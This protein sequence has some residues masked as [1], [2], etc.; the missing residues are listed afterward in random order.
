MVS[1]QSLSINDLP[2]QFQEVAWD[3][4]ETYRSEHFLAPDAS[5]TPV[6]TRTILNYNGDTQID[7]ADYDA[8]RR[9]GSF[10]DSGD[11]YVF[12]DEFLEFAQYLKKRGGGFGALPVIQTDSVR[13]FPTAEELMISHYR[14]LI[15]DLPEKYRGLA[16]KLIDIWNRDN[17][18][19]AEALTPI[20]AK[21]VFNPLPCGL[22]NVIDAN[23]YE[24][25][26]M[27]ILGSP[28][29]VTPN[30][31]LFWGLAE[32]LRDS[33][34]YQNLPPIYRD[35]MPIPQS[36]FQQTPTTQ[37]KLN[38]IDDL[39]SKWIDVEDIPATD[40]AREE[41]KQCYLM[42]YDAMTLAVKEKPALFDAEML[43]DMNRHDDIGFLHI[44]PPDD[45][46]SPANDEENFSTVVRDLS[47]VRQF[48]DEVMVASG[49]SGCSQTNLYYWLEAMENWNR[50]LANYAQSYDGHP[51]AFPEVPQSNSEITEINWDDFDF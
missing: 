39:F 37:E 7:F 46:F 43:H 16:Q 27:Q 34:G 25:M 11:P 28:H 23:D 5:L 31:E 6:I 4:L 1:P 8:L 12:A 26:A 38:L 13:D 36:H 47:S 17:F 33:R 35:T 22:E 48:I 15:N 51:P 40:E 20:I 44:T 29:E 10:G 19:D 49:D 42:V 32:Y 41:F 30:R 45:T 9:Q 24:W 3:V 18:G 2:D 50:G 14:I 21:E